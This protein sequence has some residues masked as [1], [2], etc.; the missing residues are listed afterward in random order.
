MFTAILKARE[1]ATK[2][3]SWKNWDRDAAERL[4][5]DLDEDAGYMMMMMMMM[6]KTVQG[7]VEMK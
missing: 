2:W 1:W 5:S 6:K 7:V 3:S 4:R